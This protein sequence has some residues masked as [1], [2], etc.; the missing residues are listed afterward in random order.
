M[1]S[2]IATTY[3]SLFCLLTIEF[4]IVAYVYI[5][6]S[7]PI[8]SFSLTLRVAYKIISYLTTKSIA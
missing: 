1:S 3:A 6:L 8:V 4:Y 2:I 5:F 7:K